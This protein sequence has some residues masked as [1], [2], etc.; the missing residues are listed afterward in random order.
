MTGAPERHPGW[1]DYTSPKVPADLI[2]DIKA[3]KRVLIV[4]LPTPLF[5]TLYDQ[6]GS[7]W[8]LQAEKMKMFSMVFLQQL[9]PLPPSSIYI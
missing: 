1:L 3:L 6:Q 2:E 5:W 7:R 4:F 8:T 9:P